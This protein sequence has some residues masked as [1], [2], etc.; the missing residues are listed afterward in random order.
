MCEGYRKNYLRISPRF[1]NLFDALVLLPELEAD[2]IRLDPSSARS[3]GVEVLL[4][5]APIGGWSGWLSYARS[6]VADR[7]AGRNVRRSWDQR[8][9]VSAGLSWSSGPWSVS[10][11]FTYHTGWP[12]TDLQLVSTGS[13]A[14]QLMIG[15]RNDQRLGDFSSL[16]LRVTRTF[17]L[18]RGVLDAFVEASNALSQRNPCCVEFDVRRDA[19]GGLS[20]TK[21]TDNWLPLV[22]SAG[23]LWRFRVFSEAHAQSALKSTPPPMR[24]CR[25]TFLRGRGICTCIANAADCPAVAG[26][27]DSGGTEGSLQHAAPPGESRLLL[28]LR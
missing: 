20:V 26:G 2:R 16:D 9:A 23:V 14:Q 25:Y 28:V 17:A 13:G 12:T 5:I 8:D 6:R 4:K 22:P 27:G 15:E 11:N 19:D 3:E 1:E 21:E 10:S 24:T 7:I 18:S